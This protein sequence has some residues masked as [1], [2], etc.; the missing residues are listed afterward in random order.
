MPPFALLLRRLLVLGLAVALGACDVGRSDLEEDPTEDPPPMLAP[1]EG[2]CAAEIDGEP[3]EADV[4]GAAVDLDDGT[5]DFACEAGDVELL[6]RLDPEGFG[7][8]TLPLGVPGNRAQ[9]HVGEQVTVTDGDDAGEVVLEAF[10]S[11]RVIG[12]FE[13]TAPGLAEGD[14]PIRVTM[15]AFNI[16]IP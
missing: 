5:L 10:T 9:F 14:P 1:A 6:F 11:D 8:I 4:V 2:A 15:G 12:T 16:E 13:F 7:P 3:F